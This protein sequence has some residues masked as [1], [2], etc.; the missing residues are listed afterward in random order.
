VIACGLDFGTSN[1]TVA[2]PSGEVLEID[3]AAENRRSS[4][5]SLLPRGERELY[6][7]AAAI[8]RYLDEPLAAS[9]S[10][11]KSWLPSKA[12]TH[13][14]IRHRPVMLEELVSMLLRQIR[15]APRL[16]RVAHAGGAGAPRVF[17]PEPA[18]DALAQNRLRRAAEQSRVREI[19][20]LIEP[21]AAALAYEARLERTSECWWATSARHLGLHRDGPGPDPPGQAFAGRGRGGVQRRA[22]S[23]GTTST[24]PS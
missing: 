24:R 2:L 23:E 12:F 19:A 8:A 18:A 11:V 17:S 3:L 1:S 4:A 7:G 20:F 15:G 10:S 14:Q 6:A 16:G 13:T 22:K 9:S 5:P 21:I